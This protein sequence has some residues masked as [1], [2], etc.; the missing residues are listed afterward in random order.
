MKPFLVHEASLPVPPFSGRLEERVAS[1]PFHSS[2][3]MCFIPEEDL[4]PH[5][6]EQQMYPAS[7]LQR[8]GS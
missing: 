5:T 7:G 8:G 1:A 3:L 4:T 6:P 2:R